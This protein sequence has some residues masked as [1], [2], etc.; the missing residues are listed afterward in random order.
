VPRVIRIPAAPDRPQE[1]YLLENRARIGAD[2]RLPG[3]GLLVW[4]VDE[5]V[6]GFRTAESNVARKLLHLVEADGRADLDRGHAAGGNRGDTGDPWAG[7][8]P[9][10]RQ[11]GAALAFLGACLMA[12]A[13]LRAVRPRPLPGALAPLAAAG[14]ALAAGIALRR[15]PACGPGTAGMAPYDGGPVP[16]TIR[17]LSPPGLVMRFDVL[18]A[19]ARHAD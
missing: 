7:P 17:N 11:G 8:A 3:E 18:V 6:D 10:R 16:I 14:L 15:G 9:W 2:G 13:V 1:Y 12:A 5:S 4:H 19:P